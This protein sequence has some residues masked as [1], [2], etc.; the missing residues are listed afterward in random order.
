MAQDPCETATSLFF[1]FAS[2]LCPY[3]RTQ[4]GGGARATQQLI[5][6]A[7]RGAVEQGVRE[8]G[9]GQKVWGARRRLTQQDAAVKKKSLEVGGVTANGRIAWMDGEDG[10]FEMEPSLGSGASWTSLGFL[11]AWSLGRK[12]EARWDRT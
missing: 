5:Q 8:S 10:W 2:F 11:G 1:F 6:A 12:L 9:S 3:R 4:L 7:E